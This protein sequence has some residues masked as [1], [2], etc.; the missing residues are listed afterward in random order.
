MG[1]ELSAGGSEG[2][3]PGVGGKHVGG[4]SGGM[5][6]AGGNGKVDFMNYPC[7]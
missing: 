4:T 7:R 5:R 1:K 6:E 3:F 2:I